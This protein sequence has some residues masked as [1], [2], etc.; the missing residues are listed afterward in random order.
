MS[1]KSVRTLTAAQI[2]KKWNLPLKTVMGLI[3]DGAKV[4][5]EHDKN[6]ADAK[7]I[8]RDHLS[9]R[10]DYY[11]KLHKLEKSKVSMKEDT[12]VTGTNGVRGLGNI[13]G[14]PAIGINAYVD[15]N[16]MSYEDE[17]GNK[18]EWIK[19]HTKGHNAVGFNEFD[20]TELTK[21]IKL[22]EGIS[23]GPEREVPIVGD[24]TGNTRRIA[25]VDEQGTPGH[26]RYTER[27]TYEMKEPDNK[28]SSGEVARGIYQEGYASIGHSF[29]WAGDVNRRAKFYGKKP[30]PTT[31]KG[32][33]KDDTYK[34]SKQGGK[35]KFTKAVRK[36]D[37]ADKDWDD[38]TGKK[39]PES[40]H[41]HIHIN[42]PDTKKEPGA[43][44]TTHT[45]Y[46]ERKMDTKDHIN[47]ALDNIL[48]ENLSEMKENLL[49]ALQEK[50]MEKL[51]EKKKEIAANYFAQ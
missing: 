19:K 1:L 35:V 50:A 36:E 22:K 49:A 51:E 34:D 6:I 29:D 15:S 39:L 41:K 16:A 5:K 23:A 24:P 32:D 9:E 17:N 31:T 43:E 27:P 33:E 40:N 47:E 25:K 2:A 7:Q 30:K 3:D 37:I 20:P 8:A 4:E 45:I 14:T 44:G 18:L 10:P 12:G 26:P 13:G 38:T 21:K 28:L 46:E 11:K 42:K 48:D